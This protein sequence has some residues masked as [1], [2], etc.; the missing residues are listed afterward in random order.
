[1]RKAQINQEGQGSNIGTSSLNNKSNYPLGKMELIYEQCLW[2]RH[3]KEEFNVLSQEEQFSF[4][5][6]LNTCVN[7]EENARECIENGEQN[8]KHMINKE[9]KKTFSTLNYIGDKKY[10]PVSC[11]KIQCNF[12]DYCKGCNQGVRTPAALGRE[13]TSEDLKRV[14]FL[15]DDDGSVVGM[16]YNI[17][18]SYLNERLNLLY[19]G[20]ERIYMYSDNYW[21][22][23]DSNFLSRICRD[24]LH[25]F[26]PN[27]WKQNHEAGYMGAL[28]REIT[29]ILEL[30]CDRTKINLS[31]GI[32]DLEAYEISSHNPAIRSSYQLPISYDEK[33]ECPIFISFLKDVF[34]NDNERIEVVQEIFE[35]CL[36]AETSAQKAFIFYG[37]GANGKS[38]LAEILMNMVGKSNTSAVPL[39]ELDNP[40]ARYELVGKVLNLATEN[41]ISDKGFNTTFFKSIVAGDAIQVEKKF[42]QGFMYQTFC[43]LVFCLNNLP[44]SKDKSWGFHRRLIV[45]PFNRVFHE[46]DPNTKNYDEL[47]A[48][49]LS[50][51]N[52][53]FVWALEGLKRLR[54]NKFKFSKSEAV[55]RALE[56]YKI[57][58]NPFYNFVTEKLE[59]GE[60]SDFISNEALSSLFREWAT[61]NGHKALASASNQK[62]VREIRHTLI[63]TKVDIN[64]GE[65][66]KSGGKRGTRKVKWKS[67]KRIN[68]EISA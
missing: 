1:M 64:Y 22:Y 31:N 17:F 44:Y 34:E 38:L 12:G 46:D 43:K 62:I 58:V 52:G 57:E 7:A 6:V 26:K 51:L 61:K 39:N 53:I 47:K 49:I 54:E 50:E 3:C 37:R 60:E 20:N 67:G 28:I 18:A 66:V 41:E 68:V 32:F 21:Q 2:S 65:N 36:T 45:I 24:I 23:V 27:W 59:Q 29:R 33:A 8:N 56:D 15:I 9:K 48:E 40:F 42:E 35:Y 13:K 5:T 19:V 14:G 4:L 10:S 16:N 55:N 11:G 63:D 30:D 25:E